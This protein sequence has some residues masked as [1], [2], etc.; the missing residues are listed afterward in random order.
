MLVWVLTCGWQRGWPWE[1][2]RRSVRDWGRS[3]GA[4]A[5]LDQCVVLGAWGVMR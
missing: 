1:D 3:G 2:V 4:D 5:V